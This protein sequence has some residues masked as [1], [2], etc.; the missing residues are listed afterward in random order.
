MILLGLTPVGP[1]I[2][3]A[4]RARL[5][6]PDRR[7]CRRGDARDPAM[8]SDF[9]A[10]P[11]RPGYEPNQQILHTYGNGGAADPLVLVVTVPKGTTVDSPGVR[12]ELAHTL[13]RIVAATGQARVMSYPGTGDRGLISADGRTTFALLYPPASPPFPPYAQPLP[14]LE[15]ALAD[16][17]V[18]GAPVLVTSAAVI[19]F[20]AFVSLAATPGTEAKIFAIAPRLGI[21]LDAT[22]VRAM[23]V[24]ALVVLFGRWAWWLPRPPL[25]RD[26]PGVTPAALPDPSAEGVTS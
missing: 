8:T 7:R 18:A 13:D 24:P 5:A 1:A 12:A 10:L 15:S 17:G 4:G 21:L 16:A 23:L 22:I 26:S 2:P 19:L 14:A 20:L 3:A 9:G 11:G 6:R 25:I